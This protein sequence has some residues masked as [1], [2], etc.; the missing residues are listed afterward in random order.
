MTVL[1]EQ[2]FEDQQIRSESVLK[3]GEVNECW[4]EDIE[5]AFLQTCEGLYISLSD[6]NENFGTW[7]DNDALTALETAIEANYS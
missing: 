5:I 6:G 4:I 7:D 3:L 2:F 1:Q